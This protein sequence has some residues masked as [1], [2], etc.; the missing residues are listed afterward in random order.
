MQAKAA[1]PT[2]TPPTTVPTQ[3]T[4]YA[5]VV[6]EQHEP[7]ATT[8]KTPFRGPAQTKKNV[9]IAQVKEILR[10]RDGKLPSTEPPRVDFLRALQK[11]WPADGYNFNV[12]WLRH[13]HQYRLEFKDELDFETAVT[14]EYEL[15]GEA[16]VLTPYSPIFLSVC[17]HGVDQ[18]FNLT[19]EAITNT[20]TPYGA[21][22]EIKHG[23]TWWRQNER[24]YF[25]R[26]GQLYVKI[27]PKRMYPLTEVPN[28]LT[29]ILKDKKT[30]LTCYVTT[31][32]TYHNTFKKDTL[33]TH[34]TTQPIDFELRRGARVWPPKNNNKPV[35]ATASASTIHNHDAVPKTPMTTTQITMTPHATTHGPVSRPKSKKP[36]IE[37]AAAMDITTAPPVAPLAPD[38]ATHNAPPDRAV[39][40][41]VVVARRVF[42]ST[43]SEDS[44]NKTDADYLRTLQLSPDSSDTDNFFGVPLNTVRRSTPGDTAESF[45]I[46]SPAMDSLIANTSA[47][48]NIAR[49]ETIA[50]EEEKPPDPSPAMTRNR[51]K[52]KSQ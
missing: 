18:L 21:V 3:H 27:K 25:A 34:A 39:V 7:H 33:T 13:S 30:K 40:E 10:G 51:S 44:A 14:A 46:T 19:P 2:A 6:G 45:F 9:A 41:E 20:L 36:P 23:G 8:R 32:E 22:L 37:V 28:R 17:F 29:L 35:D 47:G 4:T 52:T 12:T 49:C 15:Y 24:E 26:N 38:V 16:F 5:Q 1:P 11:Q 50:E 42:D 31:R 43:S 48:L